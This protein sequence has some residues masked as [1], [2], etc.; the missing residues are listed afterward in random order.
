LAQGQTQ[1][2]TLQQRTN[3]T[4][5]IGSFEKTCEEDEV[6]LKVET[7]VVA[8]LKFCNLDRTHIYDYNT[9]T[10]H[11]EVNIHYPLTL[12]H[13]TGKTLIIEQHSIQHDLTHPST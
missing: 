11:L 10:E 13:F 7:G 5:T 2:S 8:G 12:I 3:K 1:G 9:L 4:L 6:S